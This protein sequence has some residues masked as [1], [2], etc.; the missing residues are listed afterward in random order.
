MKFTRKKLERLIE[1]ETQ[2]VTKERLDEVSDGRHYDPPEVRDRKLKVVLDAYARDLNKANTYTEL[3]KAGGTG[4]D[5]GAAS[6]FVYAMK[7]C[8]D[9][10]RRSAYPKT[11]AAVQVVKQAIKAATTRA[12]A[13][14]VKE[15][16][17]TMKFTKKKLEKLIEEEIKAI[18]EQND[19]TSIAYNKNKVMSD[20]DIDALLAGKDKQEQISFLQN[21][22]MDSENS[23]CS[24][25]NRKASDVVDQNCRKLKQKAADLRGLNQKGQI[26][27]LSERARDLINEELYKILQEQTMSGGEVELSSNPSRETMRKE[28]GPIFTQIND[29]LDLIL[30]K[31]NE[32]G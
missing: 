12:K 27:P 32:Q 17:N 26:A 5:G 18:L 9:E 8:E 6:K 7:I 1:E 16:K 3:N 19:S 24:A 21:T 11:C 20:S 31:L 23:P 29:K 2:K 28:L 30:A 10:T 14:E 25:Q 13:N 4:T 22:Y 15:N